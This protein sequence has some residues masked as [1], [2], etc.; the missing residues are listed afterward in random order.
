VTLIYL[1]NQGKSKVEPKLSDMTGEMCIIF[2]SL[3]AYRCGLSITTRRKWT[4]KSWKLYRTIEHRNGVPVVRKE[5]QNCENCLIDR[6]FLIN[7]FV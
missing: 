7:I 6:V 1:P 4:A 3:F 5:Y 2:C